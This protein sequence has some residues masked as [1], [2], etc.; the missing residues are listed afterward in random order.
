MVVSVRFSDWHRW[1]DW[2]FA[3]EVVVENFQELDSDQVHT[4][5]P[6]LGCEI[7]D[8]SML[9]RKSEDKV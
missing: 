8:V 1:K 3:A 9:K 6:E 5:L 4:E 7:V 2:G